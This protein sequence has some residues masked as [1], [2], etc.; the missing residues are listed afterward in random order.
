MSVTEDKIKEKARLLKNAR[1]REWYR[2]N[3]GKAAEYDRRY[4]EKKA[5]EQLKANNK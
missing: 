1:Q 4:W 3:P 5:L 2:K